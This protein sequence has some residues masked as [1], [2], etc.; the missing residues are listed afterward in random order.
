MTAWDKGPTG[1]FHLDEGETFWQPAPTG[2][3]VTLTVTPDRFKHDASAAGFQ[4]VPPGGRIPVQAHKAAEKVWYVV[5]GIAELTIDGE[6][7]RL[8]SGSTVA[9]GRKVPHSLINDGETDLR[10]FFW[11]TPPGYEG[12]LADWGVARHPGEAAPAPFTADAAKFHRSPLVTGDAAIAVGAASDRGQWVVVEPDAGQTWWQTPPAGLYIQYKVSTETFA[13]N[14]FFAGIQVLPPGGQIPP[15]A[16]TRNEEFLLIRNGHGTAFIDDQA[17]ELRP[18]S[19]AFVDR[20]VKHSIRNDSDENMEIFAIFTPPGLEMLLPAVSKLRLSPDEPE[21]DWR[22]Y[23][24]PDNVEEL[25]QHSTLH[26]PHM[27]DRHNAE[28]VETPTY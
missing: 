20:W 13:S 4:V 14:R 9:M 7:R 19:L 2:G 5:E 11:V 15:H 10:L 6:I 17:F 22:G 21:P 26:L 3:Y 25:L 23:R 16:H 8:V 28:A 1:L 12:L 27:A 24:L 18:G